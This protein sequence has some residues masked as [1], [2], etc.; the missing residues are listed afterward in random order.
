MKNTS[1]NNSWKSKKI[2]SINYN[3]WIDD[4]NNWINLT[5]SSTVMTVDL[6]WSKVKILVDLWMFQWWE[7]SD[8]KNKEID[9]NLSDIDYVIITHSHMDHIWRLPMLLKKWFRWRILMTKITKQVGFHMLTDYVKLTKRIIEDIETWNKHKGQILRNFLKASNYYDLLNSANNSLKK[10][11]KEKLVKDLTSLRE[12]KANIK[13]YVDIAKSILTKNEIYKESDIQ[14]VLLNNNIE[15]L[16]DN[17]DINKTMWMVET[18]EIWE[19]LDLDN[20]IV[21][22]DINDEFIDKIPELLLNWYNKKIYVLPHLKSQIINKWKNN[23]N[24]DTIIAKIQENKK[25][26][27]DSEIERLENALASV[28]SVNLEEVSEKFSKEYRDSKISLIR[29]NLYY[30]DD[31]EYKELCFYNS[32]KSEEILEWLN[33]DKIYFL[34][35]KTKKKIISFIKSKWIEN[36]AYY[37][38]LLI[39]VKKDFELENIIL[40]NSK[41]KNKLDGFDESNLLLIDS[42]REHDFNDYL[43]DYIL[44]L[45]VNISNIEELPLLSKSFINDYK[46][47]ESRFINKKEDL[48]KYKS[49]KLK[50]IN[51]LKDNFSKNDFISRVSL[52]L[53][54]SFWKDNSKIIETF[55]LKFFNA[56]HIEWSIQAVVTLVTKKIDHTLNKTHSYNPEYKKEHHNYLFTWDLWKFTEENKSWQPDIPSYKFDYVQIESTYADRDHPNKDEEFK[57]LLYEVNSTLWKTIIAAFSLQR[58]QEIIL[59][60]LENKVNNSSLIPAF[61]MYKTSI[62]PLRKRFLELSKI[63][64]LSEDEE[65]E[66]KQVTDLI[67]NIESQIKE[68]QGKLFTW[69]II[70]DSPLSEKITKIFESE[71][72][73]KYSLLW[74]KLQEKLLWK[75]VVRILERWEYKKIYEWER[76]RKKETIISSGWMLQW[77]AIINHIKLIIDDPNSKIIFTWYQAEWT[78]WHEIL[79][80]KKEIIIEWQV[81]KVKCQI[82]QIKWYSSHI[83]KSDLIDYT[84][85]KLK[86]AKNAKLALVHWDENR[87]KLKENILSEMKK[88]W[89]KVDIIIP[90]LWEKLDMTII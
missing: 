74:T 20:R 52:L 90:S 59:E 54:P 8:N 57:K 73:D 2:V 47:L 65:N 5:G 12:T 35:E 7:K 39:E 68:I 14:K 80:W 43:N 45:V 15:L 38:N 84:A 75:E 4:R 58:N 1:S 18:L 31:L 6:W 28:K 40:E 13:A 25:Q 85:N 79:S 29:K 10:E 55:K 66:K 81:Y 37:E 46:M 63:E 82:V 16:Y 60:L 42:S 36:I 72:G 22:S 87:F 11:E 86:Y 23:F 33:N 50:E 62:K 56:W 69:N 48:D 27:L 32:E 61:E 3:W 71:L 64:N 34:E 51:S 9:E 49:D 89:K 83:G 70:L 24:T 88:T 30:V 78:L 41:L 67:L 26:E 17:E 77:W 21:L 76:M 44:N 19:N 53:E